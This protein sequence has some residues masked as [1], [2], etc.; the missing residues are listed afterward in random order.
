MKNLLF[1]LA[2]VLTGFVYAQ[3]PPDSLYIV[4]YTTG[5]AWDASK[6]PNEQSWFKEHSANT[7]IV[8]VTDAGAR[9][10]DKGI[11]VVTAKSLIAAREVIFAD[12]AV[13][14]KLFVADVQK[15]N[16]FYEGCLERPK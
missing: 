5:S 1:L 4:T 14:N 2:M 3:S 6:Q 8:R 10:A 13:M 15:L 12:T 7:R 9:Y 16:V 11:I